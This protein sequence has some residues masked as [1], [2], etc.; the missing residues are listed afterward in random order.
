MKA[1]RRLYHH[2][3]SEPVRRLQASQDEKRVRRF[4]D[5]GDEYCKVLA[6]LSEAEILGYEKRLGQYKDFLYRMYWLDKK[7]G[8][9]PDLKVI[10]GESARCRVRVESNGWS[11]RLRLE[12]T[13]ISPEHSSTLEECLH[14]YEA[15]LRGVWMFMRPKGFAGK[16]MDFGL[17]ELS[18]GMAHMACLVDEALTVAADGMGKLTE[19]RELAQRVTEADLKRFRSSESYKPAIHECI[20]GNSLNERFQFTPMPLSLVWERML[21]IGE[22]FQV[23][24]NDVDSN[25]KC[26]HRRE[27]GEA[28]Q[29]MSLAYGEDFLPLVFNLLD[30]AT[31]DEIVEKASWWIEKKLAEGEAARDNLVRHQKPLTRTLTGADLYFLVEGRWPKYLF[32]PNVIGAHL[33]QIYLPSAVKLSDFSLE[34][35]TRKIEREEGGRPA[36]IRPR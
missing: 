21:L 17:D 28:L 29:L 1:E 4:Q 7:P 31:P 24:L 16:M 35:T 34:A 12:L 32:S 2:F 5:A 15:Y 23:Y 19:L 26:F 33:A 30:S 14:A 18:S 20:M 9:E 22:D 13:L 27:M 25:G 36:W 3:L 10:F 11:P 8:L 6:G